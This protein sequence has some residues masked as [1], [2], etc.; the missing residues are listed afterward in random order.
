MTEE[1]AASLAQIRGLLARGDY[2]SI[3][4][5]P[6]VRPSPVSPTAPGAVE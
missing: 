6:R 1:T 3:P 2:G 5:I 4:D